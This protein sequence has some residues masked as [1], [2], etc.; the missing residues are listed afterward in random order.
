[1]TE[2]YQVTA[3]KLNQKRNIKHHKI[4]R[5]LKEYIGRIFYFYKIN[6]IY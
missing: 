2:D 1:L 3:L 4:F 5:Y 6:H